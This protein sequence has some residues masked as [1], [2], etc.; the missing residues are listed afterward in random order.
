MKK[1]ISVLIGLM[2]I[3]NAVSCFAAEDLAEDVKN[4]IVAARSVITVDERFSE[5]SYDVD[6]SDG[7]K[8]YNLEW[9]DEEKNE[10]IRITVTSKGKIHSYSAYIKNESNNLITV[11]KS[12]AETAALAFIKRVIPERANELNLISCEKS[13]SGYFL[14]Y[15]MIIDTIPVLCSDIEIEVSNVSGEVTAYTNNSIFWRDSFKPN[16]SNLISSETAKKAFIENGAVELYYHTDFDYK[17]K[18][19]T[20]TPFYRTVNISIDAHSGS[21]VYTSFNDNSLRKYSYSTANAAMAGDVEADEEAGFGFTEGELASIEE[22]NGLISEN[23]AKNSIT[24]Y[25]IIKNDAAVSGGNLMGSYANK[26]DYYWSFTGSNDDYRYNYSVNAKTGKIENFRRYNKDYDTEGKQSVSQSKAEENINKYLKLLA[27]DYLNSVDY[28][29]DV[30]YSK[31]S[32]S[33]SCTFKRKFNGACLDANYINIEIDG[34]KGELITYSK[35]WYNDISMSAKPIKLTAEEAFDRYSEYADIDLCFVFIVNLNKDSTD[36]DE[37]NAVYTKKNRDFYGYIDTETGK[38]VSLDGKEIKR[39]ETIGSYS[40]ISGSEYEDEINILF[41]SGYK[42]DREEFKPNEPMTVYDFVSLYYSN[43][44]NGYDYRPLYD[45][46]DEEG[47]FILNKLKECSLDSDD[48]LTR[49]NCAKIFVNILGYSEFC[50]RDDIF[51]DIYSDVNDND[52]AEA[53]IAAD[54]GILPAGEYFEP[55]KALTNGDGAH[56]IYNYLNSGKDYTREH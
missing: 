15:S 46:D 44:N 49:I 33:Y 31:Y 26:D 41:N 30:T 10:N 16:T 21:K 24:R 32:N 38:N 36:Y 17:T 56:V 14:R 6:N 53:A 40:D 29:D 3:F 51:A 8:F 52:K 43:T 4:A 48:S 35:K 47:D 11:T 1:I 55:E 39:K 9:T 12:D 34:E 27:S 22:S 42:L 20:V 5:F 28:S 2:I 45:S 25:N 23:D 19:A 7:E 13:Y 50:D 37:I 54:F 18:S